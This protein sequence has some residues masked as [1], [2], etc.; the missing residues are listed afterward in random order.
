MTKNTAYLIDLRGDDSEIGVV[1]SATES[2]WFRLV[3]GKY[4]G[5][6]G[7]VQTLVHDQARHVFRFIQSDGSVWEFFDFD[8]FE[9]PSG[10]LSSV[11]SAGGESSLVFTYPNASSGASEVQRSYTSGVVTTIES[12]LYAYLPS[13]DPQRGSHFECHTATQ[14][15]KWRVATGRTI[16][17]FLL[18][19]K[20]APRSLA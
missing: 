18:R 8:Q 4:N 10:L 11:V 5:A 1:V 15:W 7:A 17:V 13:S 14:G 6:F 3:N 19:L 16:G 20:L 2:Y 12:Y 9:N